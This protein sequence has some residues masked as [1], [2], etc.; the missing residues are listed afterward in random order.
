M[1]APLNLYD[2]EHEV[3][4]I[5][6]IHTSKDKSAEP[7]FFRFGTSVLCTIKYLSSTCL[8][9]SFGLFVLYYHISFI[10]VRIV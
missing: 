9:Y 4:V 7:D 6:A 10:P 2:I 3:T 8:I 5:I 1:L